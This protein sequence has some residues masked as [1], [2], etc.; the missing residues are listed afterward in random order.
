M[1]KNFIINKNLNLYLL[2]ILVFLLPFYEFIYFNFNSLYFAQYI[3]LI[4]IGLLFLLLIIITYFLIYKFDS[5]KKESFLKIILFFWINFYYYD[6]ST[7][8]FK[9]INYSFYF[10]IVL[11]IFLYSLLIILMN[12]F[13]LFLKNFLLFFFILNY[14]FFTFSLINKLL[15][16]NLT[17]VNLF[18]INTIDFKKKFN[19]NVYYI[20]LDELTS[21]NQFK[22]YYPDINLKNFQKKIK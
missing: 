16:N 5:F 12:K 9:N 14:I 1:F 2:P 8:I 10:S 6:F 3:E 17:E 20:I 22:E 15:Y 11:L 7:S 21:I 4:K 18:K 13:N 19:K